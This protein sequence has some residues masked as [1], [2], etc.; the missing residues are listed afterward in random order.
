[1]IDFIVWLYKDSNA[2]IWGHICPI[3]LSVVSLVQNRINMMPH[4]VNKGRTFIS[5][6][7]PITTGTETLIHSFMEDILSF[8]HSFFRLHSMKNMDYRL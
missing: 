6:Y 5:H 2:A 1:M 3:P 4:V 7:F 8:V